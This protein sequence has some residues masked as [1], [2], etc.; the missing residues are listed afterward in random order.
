MLLQILT[1]NESALAAEDLR[2]AWH[3]NID[4]MS[5]LRRHLFFHLPIT[6]KEAATPLEEVP[7]PSLSPASLWSLPSQ[8]PAAT[9][10]SCYC[11]TSI[12]P[13][14]HLHFSA[15]HLPN[16]HPNGNHSVHANLQLLIVINKNTT[17][18]TCMMIVDN[19]H[20]IQD[21][22]RYYVLNTHQ[23]TTHISRSSHRNNTVMPTSATRIRS[24]ASAKASF[25]S[26]KAS[27]MALVSIDSDPM[28]C[29]GSWKRKMFSRNTG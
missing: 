9:L 14:S 2:L 28:D 26:C 7:D 10:T 15:C 23:H 20:Y 25:A 19:L 17:K 16:I 24:L 8:M 29:L 22:S 1:R 13:Y 11:D 12:M 6:R 3:G 5:V 27:A 21:I 18:T 4:T